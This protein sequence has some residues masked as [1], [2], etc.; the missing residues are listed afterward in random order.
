MAT[1]I[2]MPPVVDEQEAEA[3]PV[4]ILGRALQEVR[5]TVTVGRS[6]VLPISADE[7]EDP[8]VRAYLAA[9]PPSTAL[10][11]VTLRVS[12][13]PRGDEEFERLLFSVTLTATV[14]DPSEQPIARLLVP[15]RLFSGPYTVQKGIALGVKAGVPGIELDAHGDWATATEQRPCYVV[16]RGEAESDPE[17]SY[18]R[19]P[20]MTLDGSHEMGLVSQYQRGVAAEIRLQVE[21]TVRLGRHRRDLEW[22][23]PAHVA[24]FPL[25]AS[26][27]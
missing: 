2:T 25:E 27:G 8:L 1:V 11:R 4:R 7:I 9:L 19:T 23:P 3:V 13:R 17:W 20:T 5:S 12:F 22:I 16:A 21:G 15:R 14:A 6:D 26:T 10:A 18:E 24:R